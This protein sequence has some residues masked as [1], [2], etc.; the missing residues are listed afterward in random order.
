MAQS[1]P[2]KYNTSLKN[3]KKVMKFC[4]KIHLNI[5]NGNLY[6]SYL[7]G[8]RKVIQ[9]ETG[10][11]FVF[12]NKVFRD[13]YLEYI[14]HKIQVVT[15]N[16]SNPGDMGSQQGYLSLL[17]NYSLYRKLFQEEDSS[18]YKKIW[19]MQKNC[20]IIILYNNLACN[21]GHF[22][23]KKCPLKKDP[24]CDPKDLKTFLKDELATLQE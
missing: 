7:D 6:D 8:L 16:L 19:S 17:I 14:K 10:D 1:N 20:P 3:V 13:K 18:L 9:E 22:L 2:Q 12:K 23:T 21:P 15:I 5:L 11:E 4:K 24:K